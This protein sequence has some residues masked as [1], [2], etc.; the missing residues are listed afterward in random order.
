MG[1]G[2]WGIGLATILQ[3]DISLNVVAV[4]VGGESCFLILALRLGCQWIDG[5]SPK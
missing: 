2:D 4:E 3:K 5:S 1:D